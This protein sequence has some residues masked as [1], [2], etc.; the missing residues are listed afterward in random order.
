MELKLPDKRRAFEEYRTKRNHFGP[1]QTW[2]RKIDDVFNYRRVS[3]LGV[4][5]FITGDEPFFEFLTLESV[6]RGIHRKEWKLPLPYRP[7]LAFAINPH[8][9]VLAVVERDER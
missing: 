8:A 2:E 6:S 4:Y 5:S 3:G 9:D 7:V 1:I